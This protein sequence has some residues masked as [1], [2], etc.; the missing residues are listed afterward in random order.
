MQAI[1]NR[2]APGVCRDLNLRTERFNQHTS[3]G[4]MLLEIGSSGDTLA[5]ALAAARLAGQ[6]I[7]QL[8][9]STP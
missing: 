4:A 9:W 2:N 6:A 5:E 1:L 3:P 7:A 8:L